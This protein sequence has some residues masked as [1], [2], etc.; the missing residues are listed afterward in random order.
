[1]PK[2]STNGKRKST[3][4]YARMDM[5]HA[6]ISVGRTKLKPVV[7]EFYNRDPRVV[8]RELLGKILVREERGVRL[9]GRMV[10]TEA[11]LGIDDPAAHSAAGK[12]ARNAVLFGPPGFSYVYFIYGVHYCFNVSCLEDG[13]AGGVL[14]RALEPLE[15]IQTMASNRGLELSDPPRISELRKIASGPGRLAEALGIDRLRDNG[16]DVTSARSD[17]WIASDGYV[18]E[19]IVEGPRVGITKAVEHPL[20]YTILGSVFVSAMRPATSER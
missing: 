5:T 6:R 1:M 4:V 7:R 12:T 11:Y 8:A 13:E 18:P 9:A 20:R 2:S 17:L 19:G 14:V 3:S 16:K 10:E 15:G